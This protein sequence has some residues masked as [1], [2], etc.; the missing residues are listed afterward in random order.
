MKR[1][2]D[3]LMAEVFPSV[4]HTSVPDCTTLVDISKAGRLLGYAPAHSWRDHV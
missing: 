4:P 2:S 1:P 3:E